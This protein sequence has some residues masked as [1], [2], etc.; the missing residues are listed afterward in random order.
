MT[1]W[2]DKQGFGALY[3][4]IKEKS[5]QKNYTNGKKKNP[6]TI[7]LILLDFFSS[8]HDTLIQFAELCW[9]PCVLVTVR[10]DNRD[11]ISMF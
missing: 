9:Y 6:V 11:G 1:S 5:K 10:R 2:D 7:F 4:D 8:F 3:G